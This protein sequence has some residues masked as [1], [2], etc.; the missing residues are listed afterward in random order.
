MEWNL[1]RDTQRERRNETYWV[2]ASVMANKSWSSGVFKPSS[3]AP[4]YKLEEFKADTILH[5][6]NIQQGVSGEQFEKVKMQ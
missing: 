6:Q 5:K 1:R 3:M 2:V 4:S